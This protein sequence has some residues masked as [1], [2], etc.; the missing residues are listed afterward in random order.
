MPQLLQH[1]QRLLWG[2]PQLQTLQKTAL[3]SIPKLCKTNSFPIWLGRRGEG[4]ILLWE[5]G[6]VLCMFLT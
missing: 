1:P 2:D 3:P 5:T 4:S 6:S